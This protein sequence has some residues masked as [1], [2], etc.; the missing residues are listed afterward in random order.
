[1]NQLLFYQNIVALDR[2]KHQDLCL[3]TPI[4]LN[5]AE[6]TNFIPILLSELS[7]VSQELPVLFVPI[8][9]NEFALAAITGV[10]KESN[11]LIRKGAWLGRYVP[12]FLRR[13]PFITLGNPGDTSQFTIAIDER[14]KCL[15]G[16]SLE[17]LPSQK[18][19]LFEKEKPSKKLQ[20]LIP[21]LQKF[22]LDNQQTY[23]FCK[24][25]Q[26][27][28]LL[29]KSDLGVQDKLGKK[30]QV[31]GGWLID[32]AALKALD[33]KLVQEFFV[34]D[35]LQKIYQIQFSIKNFPLMIDRFADNAIQP[36]KPQVQKLPKLAKVPVAPNAS[37]S[38]V[39]QKKDKLVSKAGPT[40]KVSASKKTV[41]PKT[42]VAAK[43]GVKK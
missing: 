31:N 37:A 40:K 6:H 8:G 33:P 2:K 12:A 5:F 23:T 29:V 7:E 9:E 27:L 18:H 35:W 20:E 16:L 38:A 1:M 24:R 26:D 25:L 4:S 15:E 17:G 28:N 43:K 22:H 3:T 14:A 13:Y 19:P 10:Q 30:Y 42:K 36:S 39:S 41:A 32:E 11:L 34:G 21:F